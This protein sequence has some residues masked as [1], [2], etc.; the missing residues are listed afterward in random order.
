MPRTLLAIDNDYS[1]DEE[2]LI[3]YLDNNNNL[4][5]NLVNTSNIDTKPK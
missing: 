5:I 2:L 4:D 3:R 1:S